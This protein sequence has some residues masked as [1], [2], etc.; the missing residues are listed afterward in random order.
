MG[1][2]VNRTATNMLLIGVVFHCFM[3]P[4][5]L[6]ADGISKNNLNYDIN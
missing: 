6:G 3:T 5:F 1:H 4:I 2:S